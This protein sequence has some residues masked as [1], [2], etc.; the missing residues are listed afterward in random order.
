MRVL[1]CYVKD[2]MLR[3]EQIGTNIFFCAFYIRRVLFER[4]LRP[5]VPVG[6]AHQLLSIDERLPA[7]GTAHSFYILSELDFVSFFLLMMNND[8]PYLSDFSLQVTD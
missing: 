1:C 3:F 2:E 8:S 7:G 4:F 6:P 5:C